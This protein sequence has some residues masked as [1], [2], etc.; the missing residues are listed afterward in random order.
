MDRATAREHLRVSHRLAE[1]PLLDDA[2]RRAAV[3]YSKVRAITRAAGP[4]TE[5][6]LVG[7]AEMMTAA[8]LELTCRKLRTTQQKP[9]DP[10]D[11]SRTPFRQGGSQ[12]QD[13]PLRRRMTR[14]VFRSLRMGCSLR[15]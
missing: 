3:S 14:R 7:M 9:A 13:A 5:A 11:L 6:A 15:R 10:N 8:Q 12:D 2:L 1:H 4:A